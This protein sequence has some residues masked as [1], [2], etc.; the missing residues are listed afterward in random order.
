MV[1]LE[2]EQSTVSNGSDHEGKAALA[3]PL[4]RRTLLRTAGI[5]G[6]TVAAGAWLNYRFSG[7][8]SRDVYAVTGDVYGKKPFL[9][10]CATTTI[11]ELRAVGNPSAARLYYVRDAGQEGVFLYDP[12]DTSTADNTG[13]V[14]VSPSVGARFKRMYDGSLNVKWFGAKGDGVTDDTAAIRLAIDAAQGGAVFFPEG[15][16]IVS[17]DSAI[18]RA[19]FLLTADHSG[20]MLHGAGNGTVIKA[21][22]DGSVTWF[23]MFKLTTAKRITVRNMKFDG[24]ADANWL[25][26][27]EVSLNAHHIFYFNPPA[28]GDVDDISLS[29]CTFR[30]SFNSAVQSYGSFA[31]PYPHPETR[32]IRIENCHFEQTGNHGVGMNEWVDSIVTGCTFYDLGMKPVLANGYGSGMCVDVSGG[33]HNIVV[34]DN[35]GELTGISAFKAETHEKPNNGGTVPSSHVTFSGNIVRNFKLEPNL[36]TQYAIRINGIRITAIGNQFENYYGRGV[37][38]SRYAKECTI[39]G[40]LFVSNGQTIGSGIYNSSNGGRMRITNNEIQN[41]GGSGI[42]CYASNDLV[43]EGNT[44]RNAAYYGISLTYCH[45]VVVNANECVDNLREGILVSVGSD[46]V[47]V[48][49]NLICDTRAGAARTQQYGIRLVDSA[50]N[51][52]LAHNQSYN[53]T[54]ADIVYGTTPITTI[55]QGFKTW[56]SNSLPTT[57]AWK[58][59]DKVV[60]R[61]P[62]TAGHIGWICVSAGTFGATAP[63]FQPYGVL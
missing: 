48:A 53:N 34:S 44:I 61:N 5:G 7:G 4:S 50:T 54:T 1:L 8:F 16:F 15:T 13:T 19:A 32:R 51:L 20:T 57:G 33:C 3:S 36:G 39:V 58:E 18:T 35:V 22:H 21:V 59:G 56:Y 24:N 43:I 55:E 52:E 17:T 31:H 14:L 38:M 47:N 25:T 41:S 46:R 40:N 10:C 37:D 6:L 29:E 45:R 2:K 30:G 62:G 60:C 9:D 28:D 27:P 23:H 12:A 26:D 49:N 42:E 11:A 63:A